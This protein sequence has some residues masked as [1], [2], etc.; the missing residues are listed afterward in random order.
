MAFLIGGITMK[1]VMHV[2]VT[3]SSLG[4]F[5]GIVKLPNLG[6]TKLRKEDGGFCY[7]TVSNL[8]QAARAAAKKYNAT[9]VFAEP[10]K[11][12]AKKSAS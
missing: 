8:R 6:I 4:T 1:P 9:L 3:P 12:A 11:V 7:S 10:K 2:N 5:M